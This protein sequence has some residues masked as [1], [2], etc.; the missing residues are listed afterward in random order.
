MKELF[1]FPVVFT[2]PFDGSPLYHKNVQCIVFEDENEA[3]ECYDI[4][5]LGQ[6]CNL[7]SK[8]FQKFFWKEDR[9]RYITAMAFVEMCFYS[10]NL[11]SYTTD[12][13][14]CVSLPA[15]QD[16]AYDLLDAA[17]NAH[18]PAQAMINKKLGNQ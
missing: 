11:L 13:E 1:R 2:N 17:A 14:R 5:E 8:A 15:L 7:Y 6:I 9:P 3:W 12:G 4:L 16:M 18:W 10:P